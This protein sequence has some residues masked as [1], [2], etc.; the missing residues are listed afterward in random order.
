V[1]G[2]EVRLTR[3][4]G[5]YWTERRG[6]AM[7]SDVHVVCGDAPD[8]VVDWALAEIG[9][10]EQCWSRFRPDSELSR[11]NARAGTWV[12]VSAPMMLALTCAADL[13]RATGGRFDPTVHDALVAAGYD[14]SFELVAADASAAQPLV[15]VAAPGF[16]GVE[17]DT[18]GAC[19]RVPP[20]VR[21]DLGGVGK[22]LAADLVARG[23]VER[24]ARSAL[25][26][27]GGDLSARGEAR[28]GAWS[29]PVEDP[30][31]P[32]RVAFGRPLR[33]GAL[34][35]STTRVRAWTRGGRRYHHLVDP[36]TGEPA[37]S[38]VAAVVGAAAEAWWAEGIAKAI[39]VGGVAAAAA[40]ARRNAV[41]AWVFMDDRRVLEVG[42]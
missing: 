3:A 6:R 37:R 11:L 20:G 23:L 14:R 28:G 40:L 21:L 22:G 35:T 36:S 10:L 25:V 31:D 30:L 7:G 27:L 16:D 32:G 12:R 5:G 29:I 8:G 9:R 18:G 26:G 34:V 41:H 24:G 19:V 4:P 33:E 39:V 2:I 17:I 15:P 38:G 1:L 13:H 42:P